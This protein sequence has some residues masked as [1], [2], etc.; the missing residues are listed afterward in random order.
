[1][2]DD[3]AKTIFL[4]KEIKVVCVVAAALLLI[5]FKRF[6]IKSFLQMIKKLHATDHGCISC[7]HNLVY[8]H[9]PKTGG[10][11]MEESSLFHDVRPY[12]QNGTRPGLGGLRD[13]GSMFAN[14]EARGTAHVGTG[15]H[16][17]HRS[18]TSLE[19]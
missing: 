18:L 12:I 11:T 19:T 4:K 3:P 15:V 7:E 9:S 8:V 2:K 17:C 16:I 10:T 1:M 5:F 14:T 6:C 13:I